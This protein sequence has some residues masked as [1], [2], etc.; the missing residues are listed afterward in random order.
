MKFN[1][2]LIGKSLSHS[3]SKKYFEEKFEKLALVNHTYSNYELNTIE[4]IKNVLLKENLVGLNVTNPYKEAVIPFLSEISVEAN[5]IGAVN[6]IKLIGNKTIGYNTDAYG[7]HQSIKPFLEPIHNRALIIGTGGASKA[8][9]YA[10]KKVGLEVYFVSRD[11][12]KA[13]NYFF[14][15]ELNEIIL[16]T[17]KLIVNTTP[18]GMHPNEAEIVSLPYEFIGPE[19]LCYDLIYN[20][21]E[22]N[23]LKKCKAEG[24]TIINGYSMLQLQAEKAWGIWTKH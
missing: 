22:T 2:G 13:N 17:F 12:K 14:Y 23:F 1:F 11:N 21:N 24:A 20:P 16:N 10:L 18:I 5:E 9:A 15:S 8:V 7:F 6:C 3:F 19:H 4:D